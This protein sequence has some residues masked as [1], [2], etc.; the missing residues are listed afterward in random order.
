MHFIY[1]NEHERL[2]KKSLCIRDL[3]GIRLEEILA[4]VSKKSVN[5]T[6]PPFFGDVRHA[7]FTAAEY[8][9]FAGIKQHSSLG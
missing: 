3:L 2:L 9:S 1:M 6:Q 5:N 4:F 8:S 7:P